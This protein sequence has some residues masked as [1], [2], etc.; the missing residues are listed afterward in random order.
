MLNK[1]NAI[2]ENCPIPV[3]NAKNALKDMEVNQTLCILVDNLIATENL[4]KL[5]G[6]LGYA[7]FVDRIDENQYEVRIIKS[8]ILFKNSKTHENSIVVISSDVMGEGD[9]ELGKALLKGFIYA[10]AELENLPRIIIFY[11]S[12]AY[13]TTEKSQSL[14][15]LK[16]L[17]EKGV[18]ILTC[19]ACLNFYDL[20]DKLVVGEVTNMYSIAEKLSKAE[21]VI[22][23]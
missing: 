17:F 13:I 14:D 18:E 15:D 8:S 19:G 21:K 2:G 1:I 4:S 11:N 22:K 20:T 12:G 7:Y 10:L 3:I 9:K 16:L 5:A 6:E 23:P